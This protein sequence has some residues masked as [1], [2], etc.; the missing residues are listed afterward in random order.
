MR[1]VRKPL[2][3]VQKSVAYF[4]S[5]VREDAHIQR[6]AK[7]RGCLLSCSQAEP[8]RELTQ[9]SPRLL[10]EPRMMSALGG[11]PK[12]ENPN[13]TKIFRSHTHFGPNRMHLVMFLFTFQSKT[14]AQT[15]MKAANTKT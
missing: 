8:A 1:K 15:Q 10:A 2:K 13:I 7:R 11:F 3:V 9:P 5:M 6:S 12:G 4:T 14:E